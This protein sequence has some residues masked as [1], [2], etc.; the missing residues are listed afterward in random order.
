MSRSHRSKL[1][2]EYR[3]GAHEEKSRVSVAFGAVVAAGLWRRQLIMGVLVQFLGRSAR[4]Y[5]RDQSPVSLRR[6]GQLR[7]AR[8]TQACGQDGRQ[9]GGTHPAALGASVHRVFA[10]LKRWLTGTF[11][12][13]RK[14]HL[15][16]YLDEFTF[17]W[18]RRRHTRTA[19]D[20]LLGLVT[21]VPH[22]SR[23][24]CRRERSA[25]RASR[26]RVDRVARGAGAPSSP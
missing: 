6:S 5:R 2:F 15:K 1:N 12:G 3:A 21:R 9:H 4:R 19:F 13:A 25:F 17:R 18:N 23:R 8:G 22:A 11:H 16:R 7:E 24:A 26:W 20:N 10:N 14:Q